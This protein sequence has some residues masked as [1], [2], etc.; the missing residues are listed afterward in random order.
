MRLREPATHVSQLD[1]L[2]NTSVRTKLTGPN[3]Y[4]DSEPEDAAGNDDD[5]SEEEEEEELEDEEEVE[6]MRD[7]PSSL[8]WCDDK[9]PIPSQTTVTTARRRTNNKNRSTAREEEAQNRASSHRTS[10]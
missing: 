2:T 10:P 4:E 7:F 6:G 9:P 5:D 8:P 3:R 1:A